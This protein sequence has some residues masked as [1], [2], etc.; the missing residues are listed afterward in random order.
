MTTMSARA[1]RNRQLKT[2][3]SSARRL[4]LVFEGWELLRYRFL[5]RNLIARDLK[6]RYKRSSIGFIWV[7]LNPLLTMLVLTIVFSQVF[8]FS[9]P[10][11]SVYLLGGILLWGLYAQ[12]STAAMSSLQTNGAILR[13]LYVP[14]TVF[15][16]SAV[17][18]ALVNFLFA[19]VPFFGLALVNQVLPSPTWLFIFVPMLLVTMFT[20]GIGLIVAAMI[21]FFNDTFEIYQVLVNAYYFFTPV[22]YP[23]SVFNR[24]PEPLHTIVAY[25]PMYIFLTMFRDAVMNNALPAPDQLVVGACM[26]MG[27]LLVG[28]IFFTRLEDKFAYRF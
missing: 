3:D 11:Y 9:V 25:N 15:V 10:H 20:F 5:V 23:F 8:R 17:G 22:F 7:M 26:A 28:W 6:V 21:V 18:S 13:K 12:G 4:P 19:L 16:V 2:Y 24:L 14:P 1:A 27:V